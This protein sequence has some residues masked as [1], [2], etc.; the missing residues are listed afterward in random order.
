MS[1]GIRFPRYLL[2]AASAHRNAPG[3]MV[4]TTHNANTGVSGTKGTGR[5]RI[6]IPLMG[7]PAIW[8]KRVQDSSKFARKQA[9]TSYWMHV[10]GKEQTCCHS[11]VVDMGVVAPKGFHSKASP[12]GQQS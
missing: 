2:V 11:S 9:D 8:G 3:E 12:Q 7:Q 10:T 6:S 1:L 4:L 5:G